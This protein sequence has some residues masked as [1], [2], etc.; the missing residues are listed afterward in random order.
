MGRD[1][2]QPLLKT[3]AWEARISLTLYFYFRL[4]SIESTL[5]W[6]VY[7][8]ERTGKLNAMTK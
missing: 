7:F 5:N 3:H 6:K 4:R 1:E 2:K 8:L